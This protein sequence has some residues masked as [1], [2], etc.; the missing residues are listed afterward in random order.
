MA[1][2]ASK[3]KKQWIHL[4]FLRE[5]ANLAVLNRRAKNIGPLSERRIRI[6]R[7]KI[8]GRLRYYKQDAALIER[9]LV[10]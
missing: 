8:N 1:T 7:D 3:E 2:V 10:R 4:P 6:C 9:A 5:I